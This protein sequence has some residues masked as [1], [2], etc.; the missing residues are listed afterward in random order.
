M[1]SLQQIR[2]G[3]CRS[4]DVCSQVPDRPAC[5]QD[6]C[7]SGGGARGRAGQV[8]SATAVRM[9]LLAADGCSSS[10]SIDRSVGG[11]GRA[12]RRK[13]GIRSRATTRVP[14][15]CIGKNATHMSLIFRRECGAFYSFGRWFESI[16]AHHC[17]DESGA[18]RAPFLWSGPITAGTA[19]PP[20]DG[21]A[22]AERRATAA[23]LC[24]QPD[25]A[26]SSSSTDIPVQ[27]RTQPNSC[28]RSASMLAG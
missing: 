20:R 15:G 9:G 4:Q 12:A 19:T 18:H 13:N 7:V 2:S 16:T 28:A 22:G 24:Y 8:A 11:E 6:H 26:P 23:P 21:T 1:L 25:G 14:R 27:L 3:P 5:G 17:S 10:L